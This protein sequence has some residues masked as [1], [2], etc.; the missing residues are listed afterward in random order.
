[1]KMVLHVVKTYLWFILIVQLIVMMLMFAYVLHTIEIDIPFVSYL[2]HGR[3]FA[4]NLMILTQS[5]THT[6]LIMVLFHKLNTWNKEE[7][8]IFHLNRVSM[9][10]FIAAFIYG[11]VYFFASRLLLGYYGITFEFLAYI[12]F[13]VMGWTISN[14]INPKVLEK[15]SIVKEW[16]IDFVTTED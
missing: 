8:L 13:A 4:S 15:E 12:A 16:F 5:I 1:M 14:H 9:N 6:L 10:A 3:N 7:D 11:I 2:F